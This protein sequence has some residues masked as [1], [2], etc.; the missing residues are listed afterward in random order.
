MFYIKLSKRNLTKLFLK[1]SGRLLLFAILSFLLSC[2]DNTTTIKL[3]NNQNEVDFG[4]SL[5]KVEPRE[6]NFVTKKEGR[7]MISTYHDNVFYTSDPTTKS[8]T[9]AQLLDNEVIITVHLPKSDKNK[10]VYFRVVDP[11]R[12]DDSP[13]EEDDNADDN[14][15]NN[16]A[17]GD[18]SATSDNATLV[19]ID[20]KI[21]AAAEVILTITDRYAGDNY[22]VA[23]CL[24]S[25]FSGNVGRSQIFTAWKRCYLETDEMYNYGATIVN[26]F[27]ADADF[28]PDILIIDNAEDFSIGDNLTVFDNKGNSEQ[29]VVQTKTYSTLTV[30][31]L[32]NSYDMYGGVRLTNNVTTRTA[33]HHLLTNAYGLNT[34]GT[35][36]GAFVEFSIITNGSG[37]VPKYRSWPNDIVSFDF[38]NYWFDNKANNSNLFQLVTCFE[39]SDGSGGTT[40]RSMNI[41]FVTTLT[42][43][44]GIATEGD[45][46]VHELAHQ[47]PLLASHVD[48]GE[49]V[50]D[51][52][53]QPYC[54]MDYNES[55]T[56][57]RA[58]FDVLC[59]YDIRDAEE[60]E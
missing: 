10:I 55:H 56:D 57:D 47:F 51:W 38:C 48:N 5:I 13:Y 15:D 16:I 8:N 33:S 17:A 25:T 11:D 27:N 32:T 24:N 37:A 20:G 19:T 3:D 36:G 53:G 34:D 22:Q 45:V 1:C 4:Q 40:R 23:A 52:S 46:V 26:G 18:I 49:K 41:S 54:I 2:D 9:V 42:W 28:N 30:N 7:V 14:R 43:G 21:V 31:D 39:H 6:G 58:E 12:D 35:D 44:G 59:L 50:N 60:P 29:C